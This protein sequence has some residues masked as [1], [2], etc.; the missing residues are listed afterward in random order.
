MEPVIKCFVKPLKSKIEQIVNIRY[1]LIGLYCKL[2]EIP[3]AKLLII[4]S[5]KVFSK[6]SK[7]QTCHIYVVQF[8]PL[9]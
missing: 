2:L 9:F 4:Q 5:V 7:K 6:L 1:P 3:N 8:L